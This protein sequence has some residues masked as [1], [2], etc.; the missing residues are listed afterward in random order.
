MDNQLIIKNM[1]KIL[2]LIAAVALCSVSAMAQVTRIYSVSPNMNCENCEARV[3]A[4]LNNISG[5]IEVTTDLSTQT[6]TV[7]SHDG[8]VTD[9]VVADALL[10]AGYKAK[11]IEASQV[12]KVTLPKHE[13]TGECEEE[14]GVA[15]QT[16]AQPGSKN[17]QP[18]RPVKKDVK[19]SEKGT[20][21]N[22][23]VNAGQNAEKP[24][25][26]MATKKDAKSASKATVSTKAD[27]KAVKADGKAALKAS[28][29]VE[30]EKKKDVKSSSQGTSSKKEAE[31]DKPMISPKKSK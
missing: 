19:K 14:A 7:K 18:A 21:T 23:N 20:S 16:T 1:K 28:D 9:D 26:K 12:K 31:K 29:K 3:K 17:I 27:T 15:A 5:I 4:A 10:K 24:Q 13:C 11:H 2:L 25:L 8:K 6:V 22:A 30:A